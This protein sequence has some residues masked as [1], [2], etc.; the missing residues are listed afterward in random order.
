[1]GW[2]MTADFNNRLVEYAATKLGQPYRRPDTV[3]FALALQGLDF[4]L[5]SDLY[6]RYAS[7]FQSAA[8]M[9]RFIGAG[10]LDELIVKMRAEGF[11]EVPTMLGEP[12]DIGF[13][14][15]GPLGIGAVLM[16]GNRWLTSHPDTGVVCLRLHEVT[17][18]RVMRA[19][20]FE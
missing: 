14:G 8:S 5:G 10:G 20:R 3:C 15:Q 17:T 11:S 2:Q 6:A 18:L 9:A 16:V 7:H 13:T 19:R 1:M 12:G 4:A